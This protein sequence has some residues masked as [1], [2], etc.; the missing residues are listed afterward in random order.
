MSNPQG[1]F[2]FSTTPFTTS[3]PVAQQ[4]STPAAAG[5]FNFGV[6]PTAKP[7]GTTPAT[8][9][10]N[11]GVTPIATAKP[12]ASTQATGGFNLAGTPNTATVGGVNLGTTPAATPGGFNLGRTPTTQ[13]TGF[14]L[15]GV[16]AAATGGAATS[17]STLTGLLTGIQPAST[18]TLGPGGLGSLAPKSTAGVTFGQTT[19]LGPAST[20]PAGF[21]TT[22]PS[23]GLSLS[24]PATLGATT[25]PSAGLPLAGTSQATTGLNLGPTNQPPPGFGLPGKPALQ[26][27]L[28]IGAA[29]LQ[30][31]QT[32]TAGS[33]IFGQTTTKAQVTGLGGV[34]PKTST[35]T[36]GGT[37]TD[38][39]PGDGKTLK[40]SQLPPEL[41]G[42]V[43]EFQKYVKL[44]KAVQ[45]DLS[46]SSSKPLYKVQEDVVAL[47]QLLSVVS[48][49]LQRNAVV[50][51]KLKHEMNQELKNAEMAMR[52][53][54]I[55]PGLQ[56][57]NTA[58]TE[59]YHR[60]VEDFENQMLSYRQQIETL[61]EH[62]ASTH[63][64]NKLTPDDLILLLRKLH[65]TFIALA[66]QLHQVHEAV[67][68]QKEHYLNY[69][70]IFLHDTKNIFETVKKPIPVRHDTA[71]HIGPTA[72]GGLSNAAAVAMASALTRSQ[73][74]AGPPVAG[75]TGNLGQTTG[76][77]STG[78]FGASTQTAFGATT[79]TQPVIGG[80]GGFGTA[81]TT[82]QPTG[83]KGFGAFGATTTTQSTGFGGFGT[84][85]GTAT[86][87]PLG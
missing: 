56:Y 83:F 87:R 57:E 33:S 42:T 39:K 55:P 31:G 80:F 27:G 54:D 73:Q 65:E 11:F 74:P 48:N 61:E 76:F 79:S 81:A 25:Q 30:I 23:A 24:K 46:R 37:T 41:I 12:V 14:P 40:E 35:V 8:G 19:Q 1:G 82:T 36:S 78:L 69:R 13:T 15:G 45:D 10:F 4:T 64:P 43:N 63:Q 2:N 67:K 71:T 85:G 47:R 5:G 53:K 51:D 62:L 49:G 70:K 3:T 7:A 34:D 20:A 52:T 58:P 50:V 21:G 28:T 16:P 60:L 17:A 75:L 18:G 77:G 22:Q 84:S 44:E 29:G 66:A 86:V 38:T 26:S 68:T 32:S 6:T 72:F 59:Y 9:G